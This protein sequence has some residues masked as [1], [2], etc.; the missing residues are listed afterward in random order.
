MYEEASLPVS[1]GDTVTAGFGILTAV[2]LKM[3][4]IWYVAL[5]CAVCVCVCVCVCVRVRVRVRA[6][7]RSLYWCEGTVTTKNVRKYTTNDKR[8][9]SHK[10]WIL[11]PLFKSV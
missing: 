4:V 1:A 6:C 7:V 10:T 11:R 8:V 9:M 5:C 3:W 2:S